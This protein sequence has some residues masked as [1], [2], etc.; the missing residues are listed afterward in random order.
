MKKSETKTA[1]NNGASNAVAANAA[2][3]AAAAAAAEVEP[4]KAELEAEFDPNDKGKWKLSGSNQKIEATWQP[5]ATGQ[6]IFDLPKLQLCNMSGG[7]L[8]KREGVAEG[9]KLI[10]ESASYD[11]CKSFFSADI[12]QKGVTLVEYNVYYYYYTI[13][14]IIDQ[15]QWMSELWLTDNYVIKQSSKFPSISRKQTLNLLTK[16]IFV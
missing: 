14:Y 7:G 8:C 10:L 13:Y 9:I 11:K 1:T 3:A 2:N 16:Q 12:L 4:T 6:Q 5:D 15:H